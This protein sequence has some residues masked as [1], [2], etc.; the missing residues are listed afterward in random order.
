MNVTDETIFQEVF[1]H[2][3]GKQ[4]GPIRAKVACEIYQCNKTPPSWQVTIKFSGGKFFYDDGSEEVSPGRQVGLPANSCTS[5][6]NSQTDKCV[7]QVVWYF[8][9]SAPGQQDAV[10][11]WRG[12]AGN[13]E[14]FIR[15]PLNLG[16][17]QSAPAKSL[18]S[19]ALADLLEVNAGW[20]SG[21]G[22]G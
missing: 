7:S 19:G 21:G 6:F 16:P 5:T 14:C 12:A 22:G 17:K 2:K 11:E 15:I 9:I 20:T 1:G 4:G 8:Q 10:L 18:A 13:G 3:P